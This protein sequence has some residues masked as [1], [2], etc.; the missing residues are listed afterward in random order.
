[1]SYFFVQQYIMKDY[2]AYKIENQKVKTK[3][4]Y[5]TSKGKLQ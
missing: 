4:Y 2:T 1:M 3:N 5:T